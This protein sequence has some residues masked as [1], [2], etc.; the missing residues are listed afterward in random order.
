M[1]NTALSSPDETYRVF[2]RAFDRTVNAEH[3]DTVLGPLSTADKQML[4]AAW[5]TFQTG[6]TD[7]KTRAH[8]SAL[9]A[10]LRIR[11]RI[12][13]DDLSDTVVALLIDHSGS[14][15]GQSMLL[16]GAAADVAQDF[17]SHLRCK[18]EVLGFTTVSWR[19][20]RPR[21]RWKWRLRPR[22]PGRLCELLH[23]VY[24]SADDERRSSAGWAF[25]N[26]LRPDLLKE[27]IDGEAILWASER[28]RARPEK[29]KI[30][31]VISDGA[32]VDDSTLE[33]NG[34]AILDAHLREVIA[35]IAAAGDIEMIALGIGFDVDRYYAASLKVSTPEDLGMA[36]IELLEQTLTSVAATPDSNS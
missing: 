19:G 34:P 36:L 6:L 13:T 3:L 29:R 17:L 22:N 4:E 1:A 14:M 2:T 28:L 21:R 7:W 18:V 27:N 24:R 5:S 33:A 30:I 15:R 9:D 10:S 25:R 31:V 23:I 35:D 16:A 8:L 20:G 11:Q 12:S 32:P 26:M